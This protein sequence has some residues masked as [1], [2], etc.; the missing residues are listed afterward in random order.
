MQR[1]CCAVVPPRRADEVIDTG[2]ARSVLG[3][4]TR[5]LTS[6]GAG[7]IGDSAAA[8]AVIKSA[9][10]LTHGFRSDGLWG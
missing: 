5:Q 10:Q 3:V 9:V 4:A 8:R 1:P 6:W 2:P 7:A